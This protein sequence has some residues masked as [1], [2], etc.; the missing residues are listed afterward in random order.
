MPEHTI[1]QTVG[2]IVGKM[3][4]TL[5]EKIYVGTFITAVLL[6][7]TFSISYLSLM[8]EEKKMK[9][10]RNKAYGFLKKKF[11]YTEIFRLILSELPYKENLYFPVIIDYT[12]IFRKKIFFAA[13]PYK[14]RAIPFFFR[15]T[16]YEMKGKKRNA[17]LAFFRAVRNMIPEQY[18]IVI[19]G[20]REFAGKDFI[21]NILKIKDTDVVIRIKKTQTSQILREI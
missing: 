20:D 3:K 19:I 11:S 1:F 8:F 21:S 18:R 13:F 14:K 6:F 7:R 12:F 5:N 17:E 16:D 2:N 9:T 10:G 15:I 4:I